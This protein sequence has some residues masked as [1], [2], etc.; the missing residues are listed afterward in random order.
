MD[1][2]SEVNQRGE[3]FVVVGDLKLLWQ[4]P[5]FAFNP[6]TCQ[7]NIK[8]L[9][10]AQFDQLVA[11]NHL[12]WPRFIFYNQQGKR[13]IQQETFLIWPNGRVRYYE[14]FSATLQAPDFDF[15]RFPF[16][17]QKFFIILD[18]IVPEQFFVFENMTDFTRVGKQLGEEEW[19]ITKSS[20]KISR[21]E[22]GTRFSFGFEAK[23][24][25]SFYVFRI[26]VPLLL[27]IIVSWITFFLGDYSKRIDISGANLLVFIAFN[28]TI[29]SDLPRLGYLTFLDAIL[30]STF[31]VT[32]LTVVFNVSLKRL[33]A[34]GRGELAQR[35]DDYVIGA[36]LVFYAV[37]LGL[38]I[39][40]FFYR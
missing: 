18:C 37:A 30:I 35:I 16:D 28:F 36:Y 6:D 10:R 39:L 13:W 12:R 33:D 9:E 32:A 22:F 11:Q 8:V 17:S 1:Q 40:L 3:N 24:H 25:L 15:K 5:A 19:Y 21:Q 38:L 4:D 31:I 7:C 34:K 14:R 26:F 2:I 27:I 29:A 20:T 23:R